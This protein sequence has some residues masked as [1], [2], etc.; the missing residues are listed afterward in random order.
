MSLTPEEQEEIRRARLKGN[1]EPPPPYSGDTHLWAEDL[2]N[3]LR[4]RMQT[5]EDRIK[6]LEANAG[7]ARRFYAGNRA[8]D[9][10]D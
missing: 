10:T 4:R 2:D 8:T 6:A 9:S 3:Y 7:I 1:P 5:L